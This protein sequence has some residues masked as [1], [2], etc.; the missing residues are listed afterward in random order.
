MC[1]TKNTQRIVAIIVHVPTADVICCMF[2]LLGFPL[3]LHSET[4]YF[5]INIMHNNTFD[6]NLMLPCEC[7]TNVL[8]SFELLNES[9][10]IRI[11]RAT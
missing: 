5:R 4:K 2:I 1:E 7:N 6:F 3:T 9:N 11:L 10:H 8:L